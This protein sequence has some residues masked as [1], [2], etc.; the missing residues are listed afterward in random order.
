MEGTIG[1]QKWLGYIDYMLI[2]EDDALMDISVLM[3]EECYRNVVLKNKKQNHIFVVI[4]RSA[5]MSS[6]IDKVR[7]CAENCIKQHFK[8][9]RR[10][11]NPPH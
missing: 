4:D 10:A 7:E 9:K 2:G 6:V 1:N 5:S 8:D 3:T 11:H